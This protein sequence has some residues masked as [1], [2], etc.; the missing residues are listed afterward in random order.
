MANWQ[1]TFARESE[2][3]RWVNYLA[4]VTTVVGKV[5]K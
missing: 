1:E 4:R 2:E 3:R 5:T